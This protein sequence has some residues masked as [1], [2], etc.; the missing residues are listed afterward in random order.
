[1]FIGGEV[2]SSMEHGFG[3][4]FQSVSQITMVHGETTEGAE[5]VSVCQT[6]IQT[7]I[8]SD[9]RFGRRDVV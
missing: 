5:M 4:R 1:V 6:F 9:N 2:H 8:Q 3:V 7:F